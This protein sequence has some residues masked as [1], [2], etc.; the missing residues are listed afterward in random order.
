MGQ[1]YPGRQLLPVP[2]SSVPVGLHFTV[3]RTGHTKVNFLRSR[4]QQEMKRDPARQMVAGELGISGVRAV[5]R[6]LDFGPSASDPPFARSQ[7]IIPL[8]PAG[9]ESCRKSRK[10]LDGE[11]RV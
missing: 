11:S 3:D 8:L 1:G 9:M 6:S 7:A 10:F 2:V 4:S 5:V